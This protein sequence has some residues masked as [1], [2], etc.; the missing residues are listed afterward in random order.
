MPLLSCA[1]FPITPL[2]RI[3][4]H[5]KAVFESDSFRRPE[6]QRPHGSGYPAILLFTFLFLVVSPGCSGRGLHEYI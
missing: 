2:D 6:L 4:S 3:G 5:R 1:F